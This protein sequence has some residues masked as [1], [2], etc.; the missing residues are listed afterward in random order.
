MNWLKSLFNNRQKFEVTFYFK[1]GQVATY[2]MYSI[3]AK[4]AGNGDLTSLEWELVGKEQ[5]LYV[6]LDDVSHVVCR[7]V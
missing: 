6:R 7:P 5:L 4:R 2:L 1:G 3:K